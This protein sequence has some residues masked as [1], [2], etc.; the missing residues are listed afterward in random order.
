MASYVREG[1]HA[2]TEAFATEYRKSAALADVPCDKAHP[3]PNDREYIERY[4]KALEAI[5]ITS[6]AALGKFFG[7][8]RD[9][10]AELWNDPSRLTARRVYALRNKAALRERG[11]M[12]YFF[13]VDS[14]EECSPEE[15]EAARREWDAAAEVVE[16][17]D[18]WCMRYSGP[19]TIKNEYRA[20]ALLDGYEA[21]TNRQ[22]DTLLYT[23]GYMLR[24]RGGQRALQIAESLRRTQNG[25]GATDHA[26]SELVASPRGAA[27]GEKTDGCGDVWYVHEGDGTPTYGLSKSDTILREYVGMAE[28]IAEE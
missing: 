28:D 12:D 22:K 26:L 13:Y 14:I 20:R 27:L 15:V 6:G 7:L 8:G 10:G 4:H 24:A 1:A 18:P 9:R 25:R 3:L 21:L 5:G 2:L 17:L 16:T 11:A 19:N 23:L